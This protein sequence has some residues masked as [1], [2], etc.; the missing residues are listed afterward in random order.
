MQVRSPDVDVVVVGAGAAGVVAARD[1]STRGLC[2]QVLEAGEHTGG[3]IRT[4]RSM[5]EYREHGGIFHTEGYQAF[6]ALLS[7]LDLATDVVA[8]PTGFHAGVRCGDHWEHVDYGTLLGPVRFGA[9]GWRDRLSIVRAALPALLAKRKAGRDLGDLVSLAHL[10][11]RAACAGLTERAAGYFTAG[12]HEFL[13]GMPSGELS[14]AMLAQQLHVFKG[15]LCE[16]R[17]GAQRWVQAAAAGLDIRHETPVQRL[18]HDQDGAVV[19][20]G[21]GEQVRS[22]AV[23]LACP[24]DVSARLWT[25]APAAVRGHLDRMTYSRIDYLYLRTREPLTLRAGSRQV[26]MEVITTPEVG[27]LT[28][29]GIYVANG[30]VERGGLW[31]VTA[32][33]AAGAAAKTDEQLTEELCADAEK[34]HPELSGQVTDRQ[35]IRHDRYTP[36]FAAGTV[37]RL[38][39]ARRALTG[40]RVDLAGDHMAA[41][42]VEGAIRSGQQAAARLHRTLG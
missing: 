8:L 26:G 23:V 35:L 27:A 42:W 40:S 1:L 18:E 36:T 20:L 39:M 24:A 6:R 37:R 34:L 3:R 12:P 7:E 11:D 10:D 30:W 4:E 2:V 32:A 28:I 38:A 41:P 14:Y 21:S 19:H 9:L 16:L 33:P 13:W 31:L 17:G 15:E 5:G 29:G 22:R 25:A